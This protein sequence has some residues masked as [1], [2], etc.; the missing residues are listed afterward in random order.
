M[1]GNEITAVERAQMQVYAARDYVDDD[2]R[3]TDTVEVNMPEYL[4]TTPQNDEY[5]N[6]VLPTNYFINKNYPT[7]EQVLKNNHC[8][9][10]PL[11]HGTYCPVR[12]HKGAVF[13]LY[14]STGKIEEGALQFLRDV[15]PEE[16][17]EDIYM[18]GS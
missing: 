11:I 7:T 13:I 14:Y 3:R 9:G 1:T 18:K 15:D 17:D 16:E 6:I 5:T 8:L 4:P 12:F 10:L 2:Y